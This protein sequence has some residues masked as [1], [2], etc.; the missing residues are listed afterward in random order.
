VRSEVAC[1]RAGSRSR[2]APPGRECAGSRAVGAA[3]PDACV[4]RGGA[5]A[6]ARPDACAL[7]GNALA[8]GEG[9]DRPPGHTS[10]DAC[11]PGGSASAGGAGPSCASDH[12]S[13]DACAPEG[14]EQCRI[15]TRVPRRPN[16]NARASDGNRPAGGGEPG[17]YPTTRVQMRAHRTSERRRAHAPGPKRR[18]T[19]KR[20][21]GARLGSHG[22]PLGR[23]KAEAEGE[24]MSTARSEASRQA[25]ARSDARSEAWISPLAIATAAFARLRSRAYKAA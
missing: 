7:D 14:S 1:G 16:A 13:P 10:P 6:V 24:C 4:S 9:P 5:A 25:S 17:A 23:P 11:A 8:G 12:T 22:S 18:L 15:E 19:P 2:R 20:R 3:S 21:L